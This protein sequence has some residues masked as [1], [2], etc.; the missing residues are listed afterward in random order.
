[1]I[2]PNMVLICAALLLMQP[3]NAMQISE[4]MGIDYTHAACLIEEAKSE[5]NIELRCHSAECVP[6]YQ[7]CLPLT[8]GQQ[9]PPG[10]PNR[11]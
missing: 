2:E 4:I 1:M 6:K 3:R 8:W 9:N 7:P 11:L 5:Y 10:D